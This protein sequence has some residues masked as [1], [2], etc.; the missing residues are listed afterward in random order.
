MGI[1]WIRA[2]VS[3]T[4]RTDLL[5]LHGV[6]GTSWAVPGRGLDFNTAVVDDYVN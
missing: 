6:S 1:E 2:F 5:E 3:S 4:T